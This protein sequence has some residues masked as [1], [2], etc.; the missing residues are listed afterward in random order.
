MRGAGRGGATTPRRARGRAGGIP[1][2]RKKFEA[3]QAAELEAAAAGPLGTYVYFIVAANG[4]I[5][6][7]FGAGTSTLDNLL[8][9]GWTALRETPL[10]GGAVLLVLKR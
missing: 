9:A 3:G 8:G 7:K 5:L 6:A 2:A 4:T 1:M 10:A